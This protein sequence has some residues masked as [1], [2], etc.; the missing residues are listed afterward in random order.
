MFWN[1]DTSASSDETVELLK[2]LHRYRQANEQVRTRAFEEVGLRGKELDALQLVLA[3]DMVGDTLRQLDLA[4]KMRITGAST[5]S[6]VD[7]LERAG[8]L[9]REPHPHDRRSVALKP[10]QKA[11]D[12]VGQTLRRMNEVMI[13]ATERLQ[14]HEKVTVTTFLRELNRALD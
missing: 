13:S 5:S 14:L 8:Y 4:R 9:V 3:A 1:P 6:L 11:K 7:R 2:E 12:E 10:T